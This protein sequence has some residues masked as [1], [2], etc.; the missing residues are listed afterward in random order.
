MDND[1]LNSPNNDDIEPTEIDNPIVV[2]SDNDIVDHLSY[3]NEIISTDEI[4]RTH[5]Q[6]TNLVSLSQLSPLSTPSSSTRKSKK[7]P[8]PDN[9]IDECRLDNVILTIDD[10]GNE[11]I[12]S[13]N[14]VD[15]SSI[16]T[17]QFRK[18]SCKLVPG[19]TNLNPTQSQMEQLIINAKNSKCIP[20]TISSSKGRGDVLRLINVL[21]SDLFFEL[22]PELGKRP[23]RTQLTMKDPNHLKSF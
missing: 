21:F 22:V 17:R 3:N 6:C 1:T 7:R 8:L 4:I 2:L 11:N 19:S 12:K 20:N 23:S 15:F 13:I 16:L 10:E 9:F 14:N 5:N 18:I